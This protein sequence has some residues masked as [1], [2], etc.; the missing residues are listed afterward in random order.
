MQQAC[1]IL[2]FAFRVIPEPGTQQKFFR[3]Y[4][5]NSRVKMSTNKKYVRGCLVLNNAAVLTGGKTDPNTSRR[6]YQ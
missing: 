6:K 5:F 1:S 3:Q 2:R 4:N